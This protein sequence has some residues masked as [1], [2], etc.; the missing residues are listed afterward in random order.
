M[1]NRE[2]DLAG[3]RRVEKADVAQRGQRGGQQSGADVDLSDA[4]PMV[5]TILVRRGMT[6]GYADCRP[7]RRHRSES[8][9]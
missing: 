7:S 1:E 2:G 3:F 9:R 6:Q 5:A 4:G 8:E